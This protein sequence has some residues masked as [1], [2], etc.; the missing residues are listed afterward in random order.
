M[1]HVTCILGLLSH[2]AP[3]K[4]T[5]NGEIEL[6]ISSDDQIY[7]QL[8]DGFANINISA[9]LIQYDYYLNSSD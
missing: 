8:L 7:A 9:C 1:H 4:K 6:V 3:C 5:E 2:V